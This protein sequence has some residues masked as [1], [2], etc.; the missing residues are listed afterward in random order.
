MELVIVFFAI[1]GYLALLLPDFGRQLPLEVEWSEKKRL[2][3]TFY[4]RST[5]V[6]LLFIALA[7]TPNSL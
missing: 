5:G 6:V 4:C 7:F 2:K 3:W 1:G